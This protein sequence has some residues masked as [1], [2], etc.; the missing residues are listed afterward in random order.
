[1][2]KWASNPPESHMI[3]IPG[4]HQLQANGAAYVTK[5]L[6]QFCPRAYSPKMEKK[7]N[8]RKGYKL[9]IE[10]RDCLD[11]WWRIHK[12][13]PG[14]RCRSLN[15]CGA[16]A[17]KVGAKYFVFYGYRGR[18]AYCYGHKKND[19]KCRFGKRPWMRKK[20]W[21][22]SVF[23]IYGLEGLKGADAAKKSMLVNVD[24]SE[25]PADKAEEEV[26]PDEN[27]AKVV[28]LIKAEDDAELENTDDLEGLIE[29]DSED[30]M[31]SE[32]A[33]SDSDDAEDG[34]ETDDDEA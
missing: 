17:R 20:G 32:E 31:D 1:M 14:R 11:W 5:T 15:D 24:G 9:V 4:L 2:A 30:D 27:D 29:A 19:G 26:R 28:S 12:H 22:R 8:K 6:V 7:K 33:D 21:T 3:H 16:A 18:V 13:C 25:E 23:S 34:D 10:K